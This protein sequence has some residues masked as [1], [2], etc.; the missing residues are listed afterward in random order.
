MMKKKTKWILGSIFSAVVLICLAGFIYFQFFF[1]L[2]LDLFEEGPTKQ[3]N[4]EGWAKLKEGMTREQVIDL[5]GDSSTKWGPGTFTI[6]DD[7]YATSERWEYNWTI[8]FSL[9]GGVHPKAY[10]VYFDEN[11][12]LASWR[13]PLET[14][15]YES[16]ASRTTD[17]TVP[18]EG[19]PSDVQ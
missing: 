14:N 2:D 9:F 17:S 15:K 7:E 19:A 6:G 8:G 16:K 11:G 3:V 18:S 4:L 1:T 5:L 12:H 10:V 13:E